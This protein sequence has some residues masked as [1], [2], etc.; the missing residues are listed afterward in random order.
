MRGFGFFPNFQKSWIHTDA[1]CQLGV[2]AASGSAAVTDDRELPFHF[3]HLLYCRFMGEH[4]SQIHQSWQR[5]SKHLCAAE[6]VTTGQ[7]LQAS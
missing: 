3:S 7:F 6:F 1:L 2:N 4:P 5:D